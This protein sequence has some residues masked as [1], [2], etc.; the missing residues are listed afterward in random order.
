ME[1]ITQEKRWNLEK[2]CE[3]QKDNMVVVGI[4]VGTGEGPVYYHM[5][6]DS[7]VLSCTTIKYFYIVSYSITVQLLSFFILLF[8]DT[9]LN[10]LTFS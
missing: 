7:D 2:N 8:R 3:G 6:Q 10:F 4:R 1:V 9:L 5:K